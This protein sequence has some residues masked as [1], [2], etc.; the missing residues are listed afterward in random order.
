MT[1]KMTKRGSREEMLKT[2]ILFCEDE[3]DRT[4]FKNLK[5]VTKELEENMNDDEVQG[6]IDEADRD[7]DGKKK[8]RMNSLESWKRLTYSNHW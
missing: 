1:V 5:R 3:T 2:F 7:G 8:T 6:M 4:S